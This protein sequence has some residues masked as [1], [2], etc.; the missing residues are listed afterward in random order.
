MADTIAHSPETPLWPRIRHQLREPF[1]EFWGCLILILLGDGVVAQVTLSGGKNGDYQSISWGWGLGV[2]FGVYA[3]GGISGG[4]LNPAVTLCS[5]IYRGFPWK[6][7]PIYLVAQLLGC[8]TGAALVYGNYRSAIDVFEGGKGIR[9]VGLP[10]STAGIFCTYPAEFMSTTGQFFSEVIASAVLQFAI[11]A[12]NDQK[13]LAA[14]PLAPLVL[15]FLIFA[16]G[17][18]LGWETGYAINLARDFGP[19]LVTAMIGYGSKVWT[20]GNYYFWV[21]IIA[22]FIGAALGGFFYDFFLYTGDESPLNWPYMGF[23]RIF[24]LFGKKEQPRIEHDM[25]MVE[26]APSKEEVAHFS[27][28]PNASS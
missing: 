18:C 7:F 22:P 28:S 14:G 11:F 17:A 23:D 12:I 20:T 6:K 13:N 5:C 15:F 4:H 1:A 24:F 27:N 26:E 10:T 25:G 21:P 9:T 2:M 19:R 8:M 3:A 16:I